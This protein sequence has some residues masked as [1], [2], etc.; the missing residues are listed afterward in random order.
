ML[1]LTWRAATALAA[2]TF[3]RS[4]AGFGFPLFALPMYAALGYGRGDTILA[5]V[6]I[7]IGVPAYASPPPYPSYPYPSADVDGRLVAQAVLVLVLRRADPEREQVREED[8][9]LYLVVGPYP[10]A[11][12]FS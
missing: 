4:L 7:A 10:R 2:V 1:V 5:C 12:E 6:A 9:V 3:F 11:L 8:V